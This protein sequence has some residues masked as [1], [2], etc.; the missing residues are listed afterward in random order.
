MTVVVG[1]GELQLK[2]ESWHTC[3]S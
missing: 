3:Y 2:V 1:R